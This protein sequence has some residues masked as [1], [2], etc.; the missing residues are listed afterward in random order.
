[1]TRTYSARERLR[2][3]DF[4]QLT[5]G[6]L[7][8][9]RQM[10]AALTWQVDRRRTRR[11]MPGHDGVLDMRRSLRRNLH[12]GGELLLWSYRTPKMKPRPLI[13]IADVSGSMERYTRLLL[14]F[15]HAMAQGQARHVEV[16]LFGTRLTCISRQLR[17]KDVD[18]A[19]DNVTRVV[20]DWSGG[21]RMGEALKEFNF[22][23]G[24]RVL[25]GGPVVLLISDGW[26]RGDP[27]LLNREMG[28]LRRFCRRIVWLNPLLGSV[29]Y[30]P[31]TR[32]M[33]AALP[34]IDDFLPVH[35]LASLEDLTGHLNRLDGRRVGREGAMSLRG[36]AFV[37]ARKR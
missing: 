35:N 14:H 32:G 24:R 5:A 1:M 3:K 30:E 11:N 27:G 33:V 13:I 8:A 17:T 4:A 15:M 34:F 6:E 12:H 16:F 31:L 22:V 2:Q 20:R 10:I 19:L 37:G 7:A 21:T 29:Q 36:A 18:R 9:I 25:Q 28:R 26:D 23:W